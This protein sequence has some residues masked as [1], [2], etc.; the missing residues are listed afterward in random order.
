M[1]TTRGLITLL[2]LAACRAAPAPPPPS[3]PAGKLEG[4]MGNCPSAVT[5]AITQMTRVSG[6]VTLD[7]VAEYAGQGVDIISAGALTHSAPAIDMSLEI[8]EWTSVETS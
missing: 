8:L 6:G 1:R 4:R 5:T 2:L 7:T 3:G